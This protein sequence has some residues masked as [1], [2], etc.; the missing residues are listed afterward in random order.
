MR[1]AT[2]IFT[3]LLGCFCL[4]PNAYGQV[5]N[6]QHVKAELIL[7]DGPLPP[8]EPF[9]VA[10]RLKIDPGWHVYWKYPGDSGSPTVVKWTLPA[11]YIAGDLQYPIPHEIDEPGGIAVYAYEG[12]VVLKAVAKPS[13]VAPETSTDANEVKADVRWLV[14]EKVCIPGKASLAAKVRFSTDAETPQ[15]KIAEAQVYPDAKP[16]EG[17]LEHVGSVAH[18]GETTV[19]LDWSKPPTNPD[20]IEWFPAVPD[21]LIPQRPTV[22]TTGK[23]TTATLK[24]EVIGGSAPPRSM[25][26]VVAYTAADGTRHGFTLDVPLN[27][28]SDAPT[29]L[30]AQ[31]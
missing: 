21:G 23:L 30:P 3:A 29:P 11:G 14:C 27:P 13:K 16:P 7:P 25:Q 8:G 10:V 22:K 4:L 28:D 17:L 2:L 1:D 20:S 9:E 19:R 15:M 31:R 6:E 26:S 5:R 24:Y 18:A 12:E